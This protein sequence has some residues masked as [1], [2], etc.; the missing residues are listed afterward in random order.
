MSTAIA[1]SIFMTR[2]LSLRS[3]KRKPKGEPDSSDQDLVNDREPQ[4]DVAKFICACVFENVQG[5]SLTIERCCLAH[6]Q[7]PPL[8]D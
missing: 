7:T 1:A 4:H 5:L 2:T 3:T 8:S 6:E